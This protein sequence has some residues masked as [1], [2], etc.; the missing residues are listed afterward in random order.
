MADPV[1][2][3]TAGLS[4]PLTTFA[5]TFEQS[6]AIADKIAPIK[7]VT[8]RQADYPVW[9]KK[10]LYRKG[11]SLVGPDG[12]VEEIKEELGSAEYKVLD[13]AIKV[14][15]STD[16]EQEFAALGIN[17]EQR[18]TKK[19]MNW[20]AIGRED[21]ARQLF[22]TAANYGT[23][24]LAAPP[25]GTWNLPASTPLQDVSQAI[26]SI[27]GMS[28]RKVMIMGREV[29]DV[30]KYNTQILSALGR[31]GGQTEREISKAT[32]EDLA[33]MF[34]VD[35]VLV[36]DLQFDANNEAVAAMDRD[37]IWN[38]KHVA[39]VVCPR[40]EDVIGDT[41][42]F[43]MTFRYLRPQLREIDFMGLPATAIVRRWFD[44]NRGIA[45]VWNTLGG[46]SE[47][48]A[49]TAPDAGFLIENVIP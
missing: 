31:P 5:L 21:R 25:G 40:A 45:G 41:L 12:Q 44:E 1:L 4:I 3:M 39:I 6:G 43:A 33:R 13:Y 32:R 9:N 37:F 2:D 36:G 15:S 23:N 24:F 48:M 27:I 30:V 8:Q 11:S 35:E 28:L 34:E 19:V 49:I 16:A 18:D 38:D 46:Y 42:S 10:S 26:R 7:P 47:D 20:L 29:Y 14:P 17:K 22:M